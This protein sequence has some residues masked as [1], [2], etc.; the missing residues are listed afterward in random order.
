MTKAQIVDRIAAATGL[1]K[2]ETEAV[3]EGFMVTVIDAV[4]D[5]DLVELRGFGTYRARERAP[6]MARNPQT[7]EPVEVPRHYVPVFKPAAEFRRVVN[8]ARIE[9][10][11][12]N[13]AAEAE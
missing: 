12:G 11:A 9:A 2:M 10:D 13:A 7:D 8:E 6:R 1:T 4:K 5:G 3:V